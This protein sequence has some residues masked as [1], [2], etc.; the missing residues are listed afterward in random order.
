MAEHV[1]EKGTAMARVL[2]TPELFDLV[3][4]RLARKDLFTAAAVNKKFR[5]AVRSSH[6]AKET[7]FLCARPTLPGKWFRLCR[8]RTSGNMGGMAC[9]TP[10]TVYTIEPQ[11]TVNDYKDLEGH[12]INEL[13]HVAELCPW[14]AAV[15]MTPPAHKRDWL[16]RFWHNEM[17]RAAPLHHATLPREP[18]EGTLFADM[19]LTSPPCY[20]V[21][22]HL[23]YVLEVGTSL[24]VDRQVREDSALTVGSLLQ[25]ARKMQGCVLS[26]RFV[27][28]IGRE[29]L[30]EKCQLESTSL[31]AELAN[32]RLHGEHFKMDRLTTYIRFDSKGFV[33]AKVWKELQR[34]QVVSDAADAAGAAEQ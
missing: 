15:P 30:I 25:A 16:L 5:A 34:A 27:D 1:T 13:D 8:T 22:M 12:D 33:T 20:S 28:R 18:K 29:N 10:P 2:N 4:S 11:S 32:R 7:L 21:F 19:L 17:L 23:E 26:E 6:G 14:L 24:S 31:D 3:L 9:P